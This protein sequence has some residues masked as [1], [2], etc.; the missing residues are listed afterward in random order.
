MQ[1]IAAF[2]AST[3]IFVD[4]YEAFRICHS[5]KMSKVNLPKP[6]EG[7]LELLRV[8]WKI[9]VLHSVSHWH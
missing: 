5:M 7:E 1:K 9:A 6:T 4:I 2:T 3:K 8:L